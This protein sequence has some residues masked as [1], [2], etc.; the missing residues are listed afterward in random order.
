[1]SL[2]FNP[3][4]LASLLLLLAGCGSTPTSSSTEPSPP[5]PTEEASPPSSP[6]PSAQLSPPASEAFLITGEGIGPAQVG[7]TFGELKQMLADE[8]EFQVESPFI[9]DFDAIAIVKEGEVQYYML[10]P[11]GTSLED[12]DLIE[13]VITDNP[14]YRTA[15]GVGPGMSVQ[16]AE[17]VYG[18]A[19][20]YY[21][22]ANESRE[23]VRFANQPSPDIAF[24]LGAANDGT[25]AGIYPSPQEEYNETEEY[26]EDATIRFV[27]VYCREECL[28]ANSPLFP[29]QLPL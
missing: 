22:L 3:I 1:M 15:E 4:L 21:S 16:Q 9:V 6:T 11:A 25:L 10:Y 5:T 14:Q 27:E 28:S 13:A 7:M 19:T 26:Q 17:A 24:R 29:P 18:N 2:R 12:S 8:V 23:Y 20:L